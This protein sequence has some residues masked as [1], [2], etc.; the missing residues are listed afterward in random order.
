MSGIAGL[1]GAI[2]DALLRNLDLDPITQTELGNFLRGRKTTVTDPDEFTRGARSVVQDTEAMGGLEAGSVI[3]E[4]IGALEGGLV[5]AKAEEIVSS[6][7]DLMRGGPAEDSARSNGRARGDGGGPTYGPLG[8][9]AATA[10]AIEEQL[11]QAKARDAKAGKVPEERKFRG[12]D[13]KLRQRPGK[14]PVED[15]FEDVELGGAEDEP[16]EE[17]VRPTKDPAEGFPTG[18]VPH[19]L[20]TGKGRK[21]RRE[22]PNDQ[23]PRD[24]RDTGG[25]STSEFKKSREIVTDPEFVQTVQIGD[26]SNWL[27]PEFTKGGTDVIDENADRIPENIENQE[28]VDFSF[29]ATVDDQNLIEMDNLYA[30]GK[31]RFQEPMYMPRYQNPTPS[32]TDGQM[33]ATTTP[34]MPEIQLYQSFQRKFEP[35]D[36]QSRLM[37]NNDVLS[38]EYNPQPYNPRLWGKQRTWNPV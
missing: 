8:V 37:R 20:P 18:F 12:R 26:D 36:Y 35:A 2:I 16:E 34:M 22:K 24:Q 10:R 14:G 29:V 3:G 25:P 17:K 30:D 1:N 11:R 21:G 23:G 13:P 32:P 27:R 31:I 9:P 38:M 7:R 15:V 33:D 19:D 28:W 4:V 5:I 6:L